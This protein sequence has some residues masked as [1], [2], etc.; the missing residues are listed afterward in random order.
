MHEILKS[1][2][3]GFILLA[4]FGLSNLVMAIFAD[5]VITVLVNPN[6]LR[7]LNSK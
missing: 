1:N 7:L 6:C 5:S 3:F 2:N 4:V